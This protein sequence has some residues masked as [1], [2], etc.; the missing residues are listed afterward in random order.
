MKYLIQIIVSGDDELKR[1]LEKGHIENGMRCDV[2][3]GETIESF[4]FSKIEE[5]DEVKS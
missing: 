5:S 1:G 4:N 3:E 2:F